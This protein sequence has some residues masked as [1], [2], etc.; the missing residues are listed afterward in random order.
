MNAQTIPEKPRGMV[1]DMAAL[2]STDE[3]AKLNEKL[4]TF[5]NQHRIPLYIYILHSME[6]YSIDEF[7]IE[8]YK[9]WKKGN[10]DLV[11]GALLFVAIKHTDDK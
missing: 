7:A 11:N 8:V 1:N 10:S 6:Q 4:I 5:Y 2:L 9:T 3:T